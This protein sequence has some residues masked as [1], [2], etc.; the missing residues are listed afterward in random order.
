MLDKDYR[1]P[2]IYTADVWSLKIFLT[3]IET[4]YQIKV[5]MV[6]SVG[7]KAVLEDKELWSCFGTI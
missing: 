7:L 6:I 5:S 4:I 3:I 1:S 2:G